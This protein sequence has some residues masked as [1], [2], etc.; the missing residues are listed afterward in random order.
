MELDSFRSFEAPPLPMPPAPPVF[1]EL[2][3]S[4]SAASVLDDLPHVPRL[5]CVVLLSGSVWVSGFGAA[6]QRSL[7]DLPVSD[8]Q[9]L[10][11]LWSQ[12]VQEAAHALGQSE[13]PLRVL[14]SHGFPSPLSAVAHASISIERDA[15]EYRG[16]GGTL[17]DVTHAEPPDAYILV[18]HAAQLPLVPLAPIVRRLAGLGAE[19]GIFTHLD[20]TP[21]RFMLVRCGC[22]RILPRIGFV[23]LMEQG[24]RVVS[25]E[26]AVR[27]IQSPTAFSLPVRTLSG[28]ITALQR[29][30][31]QLHRGAETS[32]SSEWQSSFSLVEPAAKVDRTACVHDAV[33][34]RGARVERGAVVARS[35]VCPG[36]TVPAG[37]TIVGQ[38]ITP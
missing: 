34:L 13:L 17:R 4:G 15:A 8:E 30:H 11:E 29:F 6:V 18:A 14:V 23:D 24:L 21:G 27:A 2:T 31:W 7:L 9:T 36:A 1:R 3:D 16:T 32:L 22:L 35:V 19:L 5:R 10:L 20:G 37:R 25:A 12:R 38:L 33:V 26:H 28:Y